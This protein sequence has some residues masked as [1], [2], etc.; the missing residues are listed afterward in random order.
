[1]GWEQRGKRL[2][3]YTKTRI[4]AKVLSMYVGSGEVANL[5]ALLHDVSRDETDI[6][7]LIE[8]NERTKY[9]EIDAE[10]AANEAKLKREL[11]DFMHSA[12]YHQHKGTWRKKRKQ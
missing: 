6:N 3:Y 8:R 5:A 1:M 9:A 2:Y 12:G 10:L 7:R 4:G 11:A